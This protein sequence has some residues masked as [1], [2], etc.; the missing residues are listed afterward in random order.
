MIQ[1][2]EDRY[3]SQ[4]KTL[5]QRAFGD[6]DE[7]IEFYFSNRHKN[8]N[9]LIFLKD[10]VVAAMLTMFPL[11]IKAGEQN[12]VGRYIYA[13]ATDEKYQRQGISTRLLDYAHQWM[14]E[15]KEKVSVLVPQSKELFE[16][17]RKRGFKTVFKIDTL[18]IHSDEMSKDFQSL[19][20]VPCD[21]KKFVRIRNAVFENSGLYAKWG[22]EDL[23]Y[24]MKFAKFLGEDIFYFHNS[25]GEGYAFYEREENTII[26]KEIALINLELQTALSALHGKLKAEQYQVRLPEKTGVAKAITR[27]FGMINWIADEPIQSGVPPYLALVLD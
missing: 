2:A 8:E 24:I 11:T 4:I 19:E 9:M 14:K 5:W 13:V 23:N 6:T 25:E 15:N 16:Y 22:E 20:C 17:Y 18:D 26:I 21:L 1:F 27:D 10:G 7:L 12:F 3:H